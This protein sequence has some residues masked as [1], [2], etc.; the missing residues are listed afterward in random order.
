MMMYQKAEID[1]LRER[2]EF[3]ERRANDTQKHIEGLMSL[4]DKLKHKQQQVV[5][6]IQKELER[7]G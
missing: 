2:V 3:L 4:I 7:R 5:S 6:G 1:D